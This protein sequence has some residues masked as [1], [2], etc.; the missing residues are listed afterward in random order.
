MRSNRCGWN[1]V[2]AVPWCFGADRT[3]RPFGLTSLDAF[4]TA[5]FQSPR[6]LPGYRGFCTYGTLKSVA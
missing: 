1:Y 3:A 5:L 6:K 2:S 4:R